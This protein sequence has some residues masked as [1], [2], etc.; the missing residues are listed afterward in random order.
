MVILNQTI[1]FFIQLDKIPFNRDPGVKASGL[2]KLLM[3]LNIIFLT[4]LK[5]IRFLVTL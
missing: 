1:L 4:A 5:S 2:H 3:F